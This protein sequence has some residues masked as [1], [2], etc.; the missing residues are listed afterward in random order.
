MNSLVSGSKYVLMAAT[1]IAISII[2]CT[3]YLCA[4]GKVDTG[5]YI[6]IALLILAA[7]GFTT[8]VHATGTVIQQTNGHTETTTTSIPKP[9]STED[10]TVTT[11]KAPAGSDTEDLKARLAAT[12]TTIA[13][14]QTQLSQA[15]TNG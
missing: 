13:Q 6:T 15:P 10:V 8:A 7:F 3:T 1:A 12:E 5:N 2:G 11:V 4:I 9:N 14:L